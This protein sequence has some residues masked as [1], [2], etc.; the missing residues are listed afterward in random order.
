M[1]YKERCDWV[2]ISLSDVYSVKNQL[3]LHET[4]FL[5]F[6]TNSFGISLSLILK[7][8]FR[9]GF[10]MD[11]QQ[12]EQGKCEQVVYVVFERYERRLLILGIPFLV[13]ELV[14][15]LGEGGLAFFFKLKVISS[16]PRRVR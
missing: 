7:R 10:L 12:Q 1:W 3:W 8:D 14:Q 6:C 4:K 2:V 9:L 16:F 15:V 5:K 11:K 13:Q